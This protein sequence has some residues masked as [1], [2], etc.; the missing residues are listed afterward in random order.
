MPSVSH[1]FQYVF[2]IVLTPSQKIT[3]SIFTEADSSFILERMWMTNSDGVGGASPFTVQFKDSALNY[4]WSNRPVRSENIFGTLEFPAKLLDPMPLPPSTEIECSFANLD[5]VNSNTIEIVL[6]GY[7]VYTP[8]DLPSRRWFQYVKDNALP[9]SDVVSDSLQ[10]NGDSDFLVRKLIAQK[11]NDASLRL[12]TTEMSGRYLSSQ[13]IS[14]ANSFGR[15]L[16]PNVLQHPIKLG[17]LTL[18]QYEM[19]NQVA[20]ANGVQLCFEGLKM[21]GN[22]YMPVESGSPMARR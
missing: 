17:K 2:P 5:A 4:T 19:R 12:A 9:A 22:Q 10:I 7:R 8:V 13:F 20:L 1:P 15:A 16:L 14:L 6:D 3:T 18:V 11:D 21:W